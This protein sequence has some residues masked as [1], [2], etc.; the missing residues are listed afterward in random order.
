MAKQSYEYVETTAT[1]REVRKVPVTLE[2]DRMI[3]DGI[4]IHREENKVT[5]FVPTLDIPLFNSDAIKTLHE[6]GID[7]SDI[8]Y[9]GWKAQQALTFASMRKY[10]R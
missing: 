5:F 2:L 3:A 7:D 9:A 8:D 6:M 1:S 10:F 4:E